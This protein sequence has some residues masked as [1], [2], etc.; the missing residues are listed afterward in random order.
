MTKNVE[1]MLEKAEPLLG[2]SI[3]TYE[4]PN[5]LHMGEKYTSIL[6]QRVQFAFLLYSAAHN[7]FRNKTSVVILD[8]VFGFKY[9][10]LKE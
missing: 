6:F 1:H 8:L 2:A 4:C 10:L 9:K 7:S 3:V 5:F